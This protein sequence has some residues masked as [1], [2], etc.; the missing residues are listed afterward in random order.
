MSKKEQ[1]LALIDYFSNGNKSNFA[2]LMG[3]TPQSI[4][5]W[6]NRDTFDIE[7]IYSKC[8][9]ISAKWLL[10]GEGN[11]I[12]EAAAVS[13]EAAKEAVAKETAASSDVAPMPEAPADLSAQF[14]DVI[15]RLE[16]ENSHLITTIE[17]QTAII[18]RLTS[19]D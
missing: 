1:L 3:L 9:S 17:R 4:N 7:L 12:E 5:T 14:L 16:D 13:E 19:H 11:M 15:R 10:T 8:D 6:L 2:K 18:D